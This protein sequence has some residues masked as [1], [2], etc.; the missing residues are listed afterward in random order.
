[1]A[2]LAPSQHINDGNQ[3][4]RIDHA[5]IEWNC[6]Y[7]PTTEASSMEK[8]AEQGATVKRNLTNGRHLIDDACLP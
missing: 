6:E 3:R 4:S 1:M 2:N 8:Q 7:F 5:K